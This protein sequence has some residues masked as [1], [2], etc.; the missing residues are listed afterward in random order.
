MIKETAD[1][2]LIKRGKTTLLQRA[3]FHNITK[4]I[5]WVDIPTVIEKEN[6]NTELKIICDDCGK[7]VT[8]RYK[9]IP[10]TEITDWDKRYSGKR[11]TVLIC[12]DKIRTVDPNNGNQHSYDIPKKCS[13][14][15]I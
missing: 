11:D 3:L 4:K 6:T 14:E 9:L 15:K 5:E 10:P 12:C 13:T 1:Y 7:E 8:Q 2:R